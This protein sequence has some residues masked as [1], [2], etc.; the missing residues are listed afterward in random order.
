MEEEHTAL[1]SSQAEVQTGSQERGCVK[2]AGGLTHFSFTPGCVAGEECPC[3]VHLT[4][5]VPSL[6]MSF[7]MSCLPS[8][9]HACP[10]VTCSSLKICYQHLGKLMHLLFLSIITFPPRR[11]L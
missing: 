3:F 4:V 11:F 5:E 2:T 1:P 9:L 8:V 10:R 7:P 6:D